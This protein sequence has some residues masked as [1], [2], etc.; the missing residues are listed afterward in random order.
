MNRKNWTLTPFFIV[1]AILMFCMSF[2]SVRY[3]PYL[4]IA[5]FGISL[6]SL[7]FV[8]LMNFR[9]SS[10]IRK[11]VKSAVKRTEKAGAVRD[12]QRGWCIRVLCQQARYRGIS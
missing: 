12:R 11:I 8:L 6:V 3:N 1:F 4:S 10:Y 5:E 7:V 2:I 9:F